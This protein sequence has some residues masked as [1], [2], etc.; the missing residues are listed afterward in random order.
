MTVATAT[1]EQITDA[2]LQKVIARIDRPLPNGP[3]FAALL[4]SGIGVTVLGLLTTLAS[5]STPIKN[6]L[7]INAGVGP[8]SGKTTYAVAAMFVSWLVL[9]LV[10]RG[11]RYNERPLFIATFVLI[12]LGVL[13]TFPGFYDLFAP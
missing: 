3:V 11:K 5:A 6:A 7:V 12:G 8:L 10:M 4:A 9:G 2:D 1:P 13:G